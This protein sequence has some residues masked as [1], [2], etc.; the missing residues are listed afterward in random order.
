MEMAN[1]TGDHEKATELV[2]EGYSS[3]IYQQARK[4]ETTTGKM[5]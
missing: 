5:D 3:N 2:G 1:A 4:V